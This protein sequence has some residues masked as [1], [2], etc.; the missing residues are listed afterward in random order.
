MPGGEARGCRADRRAGPPVSFWFSTG[1]AGRGSCAGGLVCARVGGCGEAPRN[2]CV[3]LWCGGG[4]CVGPRTLVVCARRCPTLPLPG[5][6]STIGAGGLSFRVR[7]GCRAWHPRYD[8]R[9][10]YVSAPPRVW[11]WCVLWWALRPPAWG[12]WGLVVDRIVGALV[13][14][15]GFPPA[16]CPRVGGCVVCVGRL[17]PVSSN[18]PCGLSTPGLSTQWSTGGLPPPEGGVDTS[19]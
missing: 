14:C 18:G 4:G 3:P 7:N 8:R 9:D 17:V 15:V 10:V 16:R 5:G 19:S 11:G 12:W 1:L 2:R 13:V 6:G